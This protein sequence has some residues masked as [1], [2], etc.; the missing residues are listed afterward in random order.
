MQKCLN[1]N[2]AI[3][4]NCKRRHASDGKLVCVN[5]ISD[6]EAALVKLKETTEIKQKSE[7][8]SKTTT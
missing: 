3:S 8:D 7:E 1:C 6:Y 2:S 5:C 4:C